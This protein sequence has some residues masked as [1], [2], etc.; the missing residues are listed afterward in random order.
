M[1]DHWVNK[2]EK[3]PKKYTQLF[4]INDIDCMHACSWWYFISEPQNNHNVEHFSF[5]TENSKKK[6]INFGSNI[7]THHARKREKTVCDV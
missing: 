5:G 7:E 1:S 2:R 3:K 4:W 6:K